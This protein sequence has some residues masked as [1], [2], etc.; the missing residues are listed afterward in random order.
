MLEPVAAT[1]SARELASI[2]AGA[3]LTVAAIVATFAQLPRGF[4][5]LLVIVLAYPALQVGRA[6]WRR[7]RRAGPSIRLD[8]AG[9]QFGGTLRYSWRDVTDVEPGSLFTERGK[10][11][12]ERVKLRFNRMAGV[13]PARVSLAAVGLE[14]GDGYFDLAI[15][16][17]YGMTAAELATR[18]E[19]FR[20]KN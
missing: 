19:S 18:I 1:H 9:I 11:L 5:F 6:Y 16:P 13:S 17:V 8:E 14:P 12:P 20:A 4:G 3:V 2:A 15:P 10:S 7:A